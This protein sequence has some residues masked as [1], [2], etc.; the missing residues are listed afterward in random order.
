M[1]TTIQH[2]ALQY[3]DKKQADIFF[4]KILGLDLIKNFNIS[5]ELA[6]QIF[7]KPEEVKVFVYGMYKNR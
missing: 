7:N 1:K 6:K 4:K 2:I 3:A 5:K